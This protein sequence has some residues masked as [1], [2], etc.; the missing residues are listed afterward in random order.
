MLQV[1]SWFFRAMGSRNRPM[2][3][4]SDTFPFE[5]VIMCLYI[6]RARVSSTSS[7]LSV[8]QIMFFIHKTFRHHL[9]FT[10]KSLADFKYYYVTHNHHHLARQVVNFARGYTTPFV[11]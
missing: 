2:S 6:S 3:L 11:G 8:S 4:I 9:P 5:L 10:P 7:L 1:L